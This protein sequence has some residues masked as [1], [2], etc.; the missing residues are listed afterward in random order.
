[1][2]C[3]QLWLARH[4]SQQQQYAVRVALGAQPVDTAQS[5]NTAK[6]TGWLAE[7]NPADRIQRSQF[8]SRLTLLMLLHRSRQ[9]F[10]LPLQQQ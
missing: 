4:F 8:L 6:L 1:M 10:Q 7:M 5:F 9:L 3:G 2:C